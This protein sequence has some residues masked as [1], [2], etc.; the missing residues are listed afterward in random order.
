M[1]AFLTKSNEDEDVKA[2]YPLRDHLSSVVGIVSDAGKLKEM[3]SYTTWGRRINLSD[4]LEPIDSHIKFNYGY[5]GHQHYDFIEL[6]DMN[7]RVYDPLTARFLSPDPFIQDFSS[8]QSYN[9]Y[10]YVGYNPVSY[11]DPS[12]YFLY[13]VFNELARGAERVGK[14]VNRFYNRNQEII[15]PVA[16]VGV[17]I[18]TGGIGGAAFGFK[19]GS[20]GFAVT[21]GASFGFG[22]G[23][24]STLFM[25]GDINDG[26]KAGLQAAVFSCISAAATFGIG[27]FF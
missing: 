9:Q 1:V 2:Y 14:E 25:G 23:M 13:K 17:G 20:L 10:A 21:S 15:I 4:S 27:E 11:I 8:L 12:G 26:L 24:S 16:A 7:G 22:Y 18:I 19:A 5:T 3:Y 6:I